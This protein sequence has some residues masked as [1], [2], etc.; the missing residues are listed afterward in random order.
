MPRTHKTPEQRL[1]ELQA[2]KDQLA[3]QIEKARAS[4]KSQERKRDTRRKIVAGAIALET[5]E[6][7]QEFAQIF[8]R[9]LM[10]HVA[11]DQDR[12]LFGLPPRSGS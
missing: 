9:L 10:K 8:H 11:R 7:D 5:A 1:A 3:A 6:I 2:K 12:S 4:L